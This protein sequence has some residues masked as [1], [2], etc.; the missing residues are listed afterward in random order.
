GRVGVV[1]AVAE[2]C[3]ARFKG[4][5]QAR[6]PGDRA[7]AETTL[8]PLARA[9][10][11]DELHRQVQ[12]SIAAGAEALLGCEPLPGPGYYYAPSILDRVKPGMRAYDEE[13]FGPVAVV[14]RARD[15]MQAL[16]LANDSR[17]GLGASVWT[18]D[19]ARGE[20][21]AR[22]LQAGLCFVTCIVKSD[23]RV[24]FVGVHDSGYRRVTS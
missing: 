3:L 23:P 9:D 18:R 16:K 12:D 2:E 13:L 15:E 8:A 11:R 5:L 14:L 1:A 6:E 22:Q 7:R 17:F 19:A 10:L 21:F 24:P 20:G 4:R